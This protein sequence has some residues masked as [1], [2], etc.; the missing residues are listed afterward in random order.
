[1]SDRMYKLILRIIIGLIIFFVSAFIISALMQSRIPKEFKTNV[2]FLMVEG[3]K[4]IAMTEQGVSN[5]D[6]RNQ[7]AEVKSSFALVERNWPSNLDEQKE[8]ISKAIE[9]WDFALMF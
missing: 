5:E 3:E 9:I 6:F 8:E 1:M 2:R 7:L 4:L